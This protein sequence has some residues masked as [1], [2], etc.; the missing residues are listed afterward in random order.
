MCLAS[1]ATQGQ[2]T[3]FDKIL[4]QYL[5]SCLE[6]F[7][8]PDSLGGSAPQELWIRCQTPKALVS[9]AVR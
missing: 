2:Y 8:C 4:V 6:P 1:A 5:R 7:S 3:Y 9:Y